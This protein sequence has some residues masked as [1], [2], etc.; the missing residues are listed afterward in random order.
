MAIKIV[1]VMFGDF[2]WAKTKLLTDYY[3]KDIIKSFI[4]DKEHIDMCT[5]IQDR[6]YFISYNA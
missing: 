2:E 1:S 5:G 4:E 6:E 3:D